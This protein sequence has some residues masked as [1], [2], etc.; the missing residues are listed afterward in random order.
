MPWLWN[1]WLE[2]CGHSLSPSK[3]AR[4]TRRRNGTGHP[5]WVRCHGPRS[6]LRRR[7]P[8]RLRKGGA[9]SVLGRLGNPS[10][11]TAGCQRPRAGLAPC[12]RTE[13]RDRGLDSIA[14]DNPADSL[15]PQDQWCQPY[16]HSTGP[17]PTRQGV[18]P[19]RA[20]RRRATAPVATAGCS[21]IRGAPPLSASQAGFGLP[22]GCQ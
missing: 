5:E 16:P 11:R 10:S 19:T 9:A 4:G 8:P 13:R 2:R 14:R 15:M 12:V 1:L 6:A 22:A 20:G 21:T 7:V 17:G 18:S 3:P